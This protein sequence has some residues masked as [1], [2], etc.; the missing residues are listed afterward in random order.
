[1]SVDNIRN[2][3]ADLRELGSDRRWNYQHSGKCAS[4]AEQRCD[5]KFWAPNSR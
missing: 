2:K 5:G 3:I 1:M 4:R